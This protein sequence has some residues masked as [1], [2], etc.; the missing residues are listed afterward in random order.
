M[1]GCPRESKREDLLDEQEGKYRQRSPVRSV[2]WS[3]LWS[4]RGLIRATE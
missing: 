1:E 3:G 4:A 2:L